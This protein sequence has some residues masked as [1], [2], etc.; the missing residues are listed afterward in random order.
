MV[1]LIIEGHEPPSFTN[2]NNRK[3]EK[4][5]KLVEAID[6]QL[7]DTNQ[8]EFLEG[9][10]YGIVHFFYTKSNGADADNISKKLWDA[11]ENKIYK[12]DKQIVMRTASYI[13]VDEGTLDTFFTNQFT[14]S[15]DLVRFSNSFEA[16]KQGLIN[17]VLYIE[18]GYFNQ[19]ILKFNLQS[20]EN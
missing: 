18:C 15:D 5:T 2:W 20:N 14:S 7:I 10:L 9:N 3:T 19:Q 8:Q 17:R 6:K 11:L 13:H 4:L 1:V 12:N 16:L